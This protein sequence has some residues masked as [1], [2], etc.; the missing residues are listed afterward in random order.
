MAHTIDDL[1]FNGW[2]LWAVERDTDGNIT[3]A[4]RV[5]PENW[6]FDTDGNVLVDGSPAQAR[7]VIL[8][9]GPFEGLLACAPETIRAAARL[10]KAWASRVQIPIPVVELH[11]TTEM[12]RTDN[13]LDALIDGYVI[14]RNDPD[15]AVIY[16]PQDVDLRVHGEAKADVLVE[17]RNA[18]RLDIAN[19]MG[20]PAEILDGSLSTA[21]LTYTTQQGTRTEL[22]DALRTW[23]EPI[24]ARLSQ[25]DVVPSPLRVRFDMTDLEA[26]PIEPSGTQTVD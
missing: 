17:A 15:G 2:A 5:P 11:E 7:D 19:F 23:T 13:E 24:A 9:E 10:E 6:S 8:F 14:A 18:I 3:A 21:S 26:V 20:L 25:D 12:L 4:I 16:T 22:G 1:I